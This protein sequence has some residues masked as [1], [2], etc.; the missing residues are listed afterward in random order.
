MILDFLELVN[1]IFFFVSDEM[2]N[3]W[4]LQNHCS[5]LINILLQHQQEAFSLFDFETLLCG[6]HSE[7]VDYAEA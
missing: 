4:G 6:H 5:T 1:M 3:C 2:W 7:S